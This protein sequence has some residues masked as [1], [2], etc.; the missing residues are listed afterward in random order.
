MHYPAAT[1]RSPGAFFAAALLCLLYLNAASG[2]ATAFEEPDTGYPDIS[3]M[4]GSML[5]LGFRGMDVTPQ[6]DIYTA[7]AE[8]K[9]GGVILFSRDVESGGPRN[10]A[11][12]EQVKNLIS[13]LRAAAPGNIF[14]AVDQEGGQVQR[15]TARHGFVPWPSAQKLGAGSAAHTY[16]QIR[17]LSGQLTEAGFNLNFAPCVDLDH[18]ESPAIGR[19]QRAFSD[20]PHLVTAHTRAYVEALNDN[21]II[22]CLKHF[23]GHGSARSDTHNEFTDIGPPGSTT[24]SP[25]TG[26]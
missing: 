3:I 18:P 14:V 13:Q 22:S 19:L 10:I 21:G 23:P 7:L 1:F 20:A 4:A 25:P 8:Q 5:M 15:L 2:P 6:D 24:N 17:D 26:C 16:T 11:S 9:I 12:P